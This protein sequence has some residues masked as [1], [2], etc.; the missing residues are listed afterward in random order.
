[1]PGAFELITRPF[2]SPNIR[3]SGAQKIAAFDDPEQGFAVIHG[4]PA[5][6]LNLTRTTSISISRSMA[7]ETQRRVDTMRIYQ[8]E[9]DGTVNKDSYLDV[10]VA[11]RLRLQ[12]GAGRMTRH[13]R[14][15]PESDNV[16]LLDKDKIYNTALGGNF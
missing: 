1:M 11:N 15:Q 7:Q 9:D 3:P 16:K 8:K 13:Y 14:R 5:K 12:D 6:Q 10:D 4:N 2:V